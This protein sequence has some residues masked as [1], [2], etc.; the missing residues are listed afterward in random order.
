VPDVDRATQASRAAWADIDRDAQE[1]VADCI[2]V[3]DGARTNAS[4]WPAARK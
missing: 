4:R 3:S 1:Y 2:V